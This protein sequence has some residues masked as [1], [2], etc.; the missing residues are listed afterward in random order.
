MSAGQLE[1]LETEL[2]ELTESEQRILLDRLARRLSDRAARRTSDFTADLDAMSGD[3]E[4]HHELA[5]I[6]HEL[7]STDADGLELVP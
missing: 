4:I 3:P 1:R 5:V 7:R 2:D 6:D